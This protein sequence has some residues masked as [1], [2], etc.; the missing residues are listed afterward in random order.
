MPPAFGGAAMA[1]GV[2][3]LPTAEP[4]PP[5]GALLGFGTGGTA[6]ANISEIVRDALEELDLHRGRKSR[7]DDRR[8]KLKKKDKKKKKKNHSSSSSG[9]RRSSS[10]G[11]S[12]SEGGP[13]PPNKK[14]PQ[15]VKGKDLEKAR[16]TQEM[17]V[18]VCGLRVK[19]RSDL[20]ALSNKYP[21]MLAGLFLIQVR[22][23][24]MM[25]D[26][27][28]VKELMQ[29]DPA[30]WGSTMSNLK[31]TRDLREI[32]LLC[33]VMHLLNTD[34][35]PLAAD[36]LAQRIKEVMMAKGKSGGSWEKGNLLSLMACDSS[37]TA[38]LPDGCLDL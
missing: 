23:K 24:L 30:R 22:N 6:P 26:P 25:G 11:S 19:R 14:Y 33:R 27:S 20:I 36:L 34:K 7:K 4:I 13:A 17:L 18:R 37:S 10:K 2:P 9:S 31:D 21:G 8:D 28:S 12:S 1:A 5:A 16:I 29:T 35:N 32:Q 3:V 15:W 38:P